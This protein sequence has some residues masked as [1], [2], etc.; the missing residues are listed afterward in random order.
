MIYITSRENLRKL[1]SINNPFV[2]SFVDEAEDLLENDPSYKDLPFSDVMTLPIV[3]IEYDELEE[4]GYTLDTFM[5]Q[6][7]ELAS[8]IK[9]T[10]DENRDIICQCQYGESRSA[11]C[12]AAIKEH[13]F[14]NGIEV[15]TDYRYIPNKL[16]YHKVMDALKE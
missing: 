14:K 12:A 16:I 3:D 5:P 6:A 2:I 10:I 9:R 4:Y 1:Y 11:G 8:R 15:F 13:F 7:K